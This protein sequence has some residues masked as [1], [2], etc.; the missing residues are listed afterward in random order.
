M[1]GYHRYQTRTAFESLDRLYACLRLYINFFQPTTKLVAKT[2]HGSRVHKLYDTAKTPYQR[3]LDSGTLAES[4]RAEL[5]ATYSSA[6]PVRL[7]TQINDNLAQLWK[8]AEHPASVTRIT[9]QPGGS[10]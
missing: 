10:R 7:L 1:V 3:L 2:R 4:K 6:N 9:T 5:A 8:L